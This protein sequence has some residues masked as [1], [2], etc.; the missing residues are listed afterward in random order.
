MNNK[1]G[2]TLIELLIVLVIVGVLIGIA[3]P[4]V[5]RNLPVAKQTA[6]RE[7]VK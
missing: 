6:F 7:N 3:V 4:A 2:F 5:Q 1:P